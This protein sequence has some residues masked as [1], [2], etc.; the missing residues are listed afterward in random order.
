[1]F[2]GGANGPSTTPDRI[3]ESNIAFEN[4]GEEFAPV[5]DVNGDT[6]ADIAIGN[7]NWSNGVD[8]VG[9]VLV[10][11]GSASGI[12]TTSSAVI[13]G[14]QAS[15]LFGVA[16]ASAGDTDNDGYDDILVGATN[17]D[18]GLF[19][20]NGAMFLYFGGPTG[21]SLTPDWSAY[22]DGSNFGFGVSLASIGDVNTDGYVDIIAA[23][24]SDEIQAYYGS[25]SG[26]ASEPDWVYYDNDIS[27]FNH[28]NQFAHGDVNNDGYDDVIVG[29]PNYRHTS[30]MGG[31]GTT[32]LFQGSRT[33]LNPVADWSEESSSDFNSDFGYAVASGGDLNA[34]GFD[35]V[36]IGA[37]QFSGNSQLS[38]GRVYLY[39]GN[40]ELLNIKPHQVVY[41]STLGGGGFSEGLASGDFNG[42]GSPDFVASDG[43]YNVGGSGGAIF[44]WYGTTS[45]YYADSPDWTYISSSSAQYFGGTG[46]VSAGD[47]DNDG[48]DDVVV[49]DLNYDFD[50]SGFPTNGA[51]FLFSGSASGLSLSP[52]WTYIGNEGDRIGYSITNAGDVNGDTYDDILASV[53]GLGAVS[54]FYGSASGPSLTPDWTHLGSSSD[55]YANTLSGVGDV[56]GDT[57]DDFIVTAPSYTNG[58]NSEGAVYLFYG[59]AA[60]PSTTPDW[61]AET[62]AVDANLGSKDYSQGWGSP[63]GHGDFNSDGYSDFA[64]GAPQYNNFG[65]NDYA[66][67]VYVYNGSPTGPGAG[68]DV[69]L[70]ENPYSYFGNGVTSPGDVNNDGY[71]DLVVGA[72]EIDEEPRPPN[73]S[74][75]QLYEG[76]VYVYYG[77]SGGLSTNEDWTAETNT[78]ET[79]MGQTLAP[80]GDANGDGYDDFIAGALLYTKLTLGIQTGAVYIYFSQGR[81]FVEETDG[82]TDVVE[83]GATDTFDVYL[84]SQPNTDVVFDLL[85]LDTGAAILSTTTL[86]FTSLNW[87]SVQSVTVSAVPDGDTRDERVPI[88]VSVNRALSDDAF[89]DLYPQHVLALVTDDG[90]G[91]GAVAPTVTA[92]AATSISSTTATLNGEITNTGG[93]NASVRG[94]NFGLT[95]VYGSSTSASGSFGVGTFSLSLT[96]L[97]CNTL[98]HFEAYATNSAG[99]GDSSDLTFTTSACP[100]TPTSTPTTTSSGG[101]G[102]SS[103]S[104]AA[105]STKA[106]STTPITP[107]PPVQ[108]SVVKTTSPTPSKPKL[109][110][111]TGDIDRSELTI[112][113]QIVKAP[114]VK[115]PATPPRAVVEEK[116]VREVLPKSEGG[117]K[118]VLAASIEKIRQV[119]D[120]VE[121]K[122]WGEIITALGLISLI[123][124]PLITSLRIQSVRDAI[125]VVRRLFSLLLPR[126]RRIVEPWGTV[127]DA[128]TKRPLDPAFVALIA[129]DTNEEVT[130]AVTDLEGRYGFLV[131]PGRYRV[132]P[133]KT[134][135]AFPSRELYRN[136]NDYVYDNLYFGEELVVDNETTVLRRNIPMDAQGRDWN[137]EEKV[138]MGIVS[139]RKKRQ[140]IIILVNTFFIVGALYSFYVIWVSPNLWNIVTTVLYVTIWTAQ[141]LWKR[142]FHLTT[143][144]RRKSGGAVPFALIKV[145]LQDQSVVIKQV[146]ADMHGKFYFLVAPGKY[147]VT[148]E[149]KDMQGEYH[150]VHTIDMVN[151]PRGIFLKDI[152]LPG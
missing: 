10:Y 122:P 127:Y 50:G 128:R 92:S 15:S 23:Q 26:F 104:K 24:S 58:E 53:T 152:V 98:Y 66:G 75:G 30:T 112:P 54:L 21:P 8:I 97:T 5:G 123:L 72:P 77:S 79:W 37:P 132:E 44:G 103:G 49:G 115:P 125:L 38:E 145:Y 39:Y 86:T 121:G 43:S 88:R 134:H 41:G 106:S 45:G 146:V 4:L 71:D 36:I 144:V 17:Y 126:R 61:M 80:L 76:R 89:D 107:P 70:K 85:S 32:Y 73:E 13:E 34:D 22:G 78:S 28:L 149:E 113:P 110:A 105:T 82:S 14:D 143:V 68:E 100:T 31:F 147:K 120:S 135:Y 9:R 48:Y 136:H 7:L 33:G 101:G 55:D 63:L 130:S 40:A 60:G 87:D 151:L 137:E 90:L 142:E 139:S 99:V 6:Y 114:E 118:R 25:V 83:G 20:D 67:A 11:Y 94:F 56:N 27:D 62:N 16:V 96:N 93:E 74:S 91:G 140:V 150:V 108:P 81:F 3:I 51:V 119:V 131:K 42:D 138:R 124:R 2:Y 59:G 46:S 84:D 29:S 47:F 69:F 35:D 117:V 12:G 102:S 19:I 141:M 116:I 52:D 111:G 1:V 109:S 148:V 18:S 95:A 57:Y 65:Q 129:L 133:Q 64:V